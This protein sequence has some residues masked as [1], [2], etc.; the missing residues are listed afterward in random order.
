MEVTVALT[1]PNKNDI[2][3]VQQE[4]ETYNKS[5]KIGNITW[6]AR[7]WGP[8]GKYWVIPWR[9]MTDKFFLYNVNR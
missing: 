3:K 1:V 5:G 9:R 8:V 7:H 2:A 6:I 4:L